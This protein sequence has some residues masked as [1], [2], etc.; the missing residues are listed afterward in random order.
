VL[1]KL[2]ASC[3]NISV[4]YAVI[5]K[6][7]R[8]LG[9]PCDFGWSD[10]GSWNAVHDLS[11]SDAQKNVLKTDALLI[12]S[13]G[14][15]VDAPGKLVAGIGLRDLVIVE[16]KDALLIARRDEAQKVSQLVK[17]LEQQR[18]DDLL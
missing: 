16:T 12:D 17:L 13:A 5:E 11:K 6:S 18:R 15:L 1:K 2:Y 3:E 8:I 7:R 10:V 14:L 9:I 4:D